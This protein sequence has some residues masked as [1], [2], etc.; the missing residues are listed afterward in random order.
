[1]GGLHLAWLSTALAGVGGKL[2]GKV[3]DASTGKPLPGVNIILD[4]TP[5][6]TA[7]NEEGEYYILNIPPG[8]YTVKFMMI[9][10]QSVIQQGVKIT[11]AFTNR[12]NVQLRPTVLQA[13][14]AVVVTAERPLIQRDATSK[15]V[16]MD[17][18]ELTSMP[19]VDFRDVL[20]TQAGFTVDASGGLHVRGGRTKELRYFIDG[21]PVEN[22]IEGDYSGIIDQ[23]AIQELSVISGTFNAEYGQAMSGVV[24]IITKEG[25]SNFSGKL[26]YMTDQLN[27]SPYHSAG[28]FEGVNDT[29]YQYVDL[30]PILLESLKQAPTGEYPTAFLPMV[31]LPLRGRF[32]L[33][34]G[35]PFLIPSSGFFINFY[36]RDVRSQLPHGI[37]LAQ[38][39]QGKL[40]IPVGSNIKTALELFS[41]ARL[42]Q[43]YSHPWKYLPTHHAH[44]YDAHDRLGLNIT[45]TLRHSAFYSL[46][47]S[48]QR[49]GVRVGVGNKALDQYEQ[50]LTDASVYF[51]KAG[52]QGIYTNNRSRAFLV[53]FDLTDQINER[54]LIK[55]GFSYTY[56]WM[57]LHQEEEPWPGGVNFKDDTTFT[58]LEGDFYIQDKIEFPFIILNIGL[59]FDY[60]DPK[61][62]M[63]PDIYRFGYRDSNNVFHMADLKPVAPKYQWSPR[64]GLAFPVT[65]KT[66]F[67]FS[68]GHFFQNPDYEA[69]F[70]NARKDLSS[71]LPLVG[72]P[73]VKAQKT[74]AFETGF[75]QVLGPTAAL[76]ISAWSK[77]IRGLLSTQQIRYLSTQYVVYTNTDF[78]SVRGVDFTFR[79]RVAKYWSGTLNYTFSVAKGNN[80]N[81]I[82][83]YFS[84]YTQEEVPHEEY[85]L[86]FDQRHDFSFNLDV[87]TPRLFHPQLLADLSANLLITAG[88][89]LP[90][91]P[92]V[93]PTVRVEINSGRM[94][95]TFSADLRV[96]KRFHLAGLNCVAQFEV[97][98]LTDYRN[99]RFVY[100]RT[101][102]PFDPGFSGVGTSADANHNPA[103]LGPRRAIKAGFYVSW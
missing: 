24:N 98:N 54:H 20:A 3:T 91:T 30:R 8:H 83:G 102:K 44:R 53:K 74:I 25:G 68:Y 46:A 63:W 60:S 13:E 14:E 7:T 34:F 70:Y 84:A 76:E 58:P 85:Y 99:V 17:A 92:Y 95:W 48:W 31:D 80:S 42:S 49:T 18:Q 28:A 90:Y 10:Y 72:N 29:A 79:K 26:E 41:S 97:D 89:G 47:L 82:A 59:R 39:F 73:A 6:G 33:S 12:L 101:G 11:S 37:S 69:L 93:D 2:A 56:H 45:H 71:A 43:G 23:N 38:D 61:A 55:T 87:R 88:S 57:H 51:Y 4:G 100:P 66:V 86:D 40:T 77:D 19:V 96:K 94:P 1:M 16:V 52:D 5:Y 78:A 50:P 67:H 81:P 64:L 62:S 15:V 32:S 22:P 65:D 21:I 27:S 36:S 75:K 35:G 103:H 9:G